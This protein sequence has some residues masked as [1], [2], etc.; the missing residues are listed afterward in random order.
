[1]DLD[2][3]LND[4]PAEGASATDILRADHREVRRLFEEFVEDRGEPL[5]R[6]VAARSLCLQIELHDAIEREVFYPALRE[7]QRAKVDWFLH[8]HD[9][10]MRI[11]LDVRDRE[12]WDDQ[13]DAVMSRLRTLVER[14][15]R[16]E[17]E[18]LFPLV[19]AMDAGW[20][21][22]LGIAI[23]RQ[24]EA[25]TRSTEEFEGPAT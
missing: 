6:K 19:E 8:E 12:E 1:M 20:L 22:E 2:S 17:E 14:H 24:K 13:C 25:L 9:E 15:A 11:V 3:A 7:S 21:R 23:V 5:V 4:K 16:E 18:E 10:V